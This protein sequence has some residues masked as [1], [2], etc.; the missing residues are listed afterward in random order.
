M[1][2]LLI[3]NNI[4]AMKG[5]D[6]VLNGIFYNIKWTPVFLKL[7]TNYKII[8]NG[9]ADSQKIALSKTIV[10]IMVGIILFLALDSYINQGLGTIVC[11]PPSS[12]KY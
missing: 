2:V 1:L 12:T 6:Y 9:V 11:F 5:I 7:K 4:K 10:G 3:E 8:S